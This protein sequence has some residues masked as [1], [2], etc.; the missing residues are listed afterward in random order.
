MGIITWQAK[1]WISVI[2]L[3]RFLEQHALESH[4]CH[5]K[6]WAKRMLRKIVKEVQVLPNGNHSS[7]E[8]G[9]ED[10]MSTWKSYVQDLIKELEVVQEGRFTCIQ[11]WVICAHK[12]TI[13]SC[14][15]E[16]C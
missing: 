14:F 7:V 4:T 11:L 8:N 5:G 12:D 9:D 16:G 6:I 3:K 1:M 2:F 13:Q 15:G 10:I